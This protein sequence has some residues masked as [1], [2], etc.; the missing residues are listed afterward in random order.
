[1]WK[2]ILVLVFGL[3]AI[4]L[5]VW[6]VVRYTEARRIRL[7][8]TASGSTQPANSYS[9]EQA[10]ERAKADRGEPIGSGAR[11]E[12]PAELKHYSERYW[13]LATQVAEI[14]RQRVHTCQDF[15][16]LAAMIQRGEVVTVPAATDSYVLIG[17]GE[18]ADQDLFTKWEEDK[19]VELQDYGS[20]QTLARN[21]GGRTYNL[22]NPVDRYDMKVNMLMSLRPEALKVMEEVATAYHR[23]FG[24][25]LAV[26][27]LVRPEQ[28]QRALRRVNRNAVLID[29]PPHST[30]LAFDIDYRYMSGAEQSFVMAQLARIKNEGRIEAIRERNANY[31]IFAFVD[32]TRPNDEL[33]TTS[34]EKAGAPPQEAHH[35]EAKPEKRQ[36]KSKKTK[37][38]AAR[39][40]SRLRRRR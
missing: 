29:T 26:S 32:G 36:V 24:R 2:R 19:N 8:T 33:I 22:D 21:F 13:F 11:V 6:A 3:A 14:E 37:P 28:Y 31:H 34:L 40:T 1:M 4:G 25:P 5:G 10:I 16:D 17:V 38:R 18:C 35:A 27:S 20:L 7:A 15:V 23:Q 39:S 9:W 12:T 30:G